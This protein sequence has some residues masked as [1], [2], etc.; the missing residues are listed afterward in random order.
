[1]LTLTY[2]N[3]IKASGPSGPLVNLGCVIEGHELVSVFRDI[4]E[5]KI[6]T[7]SF[8]HIRVAISICLLI[9]DLIPV[10]NTTP[11]FKKSLRIVQ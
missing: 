6:S 1:M 5:N 7:I 8:N 4:S 3:I 2:F 11:H 10:D 9:N